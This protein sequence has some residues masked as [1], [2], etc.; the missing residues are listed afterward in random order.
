MINRSTQLHD[1]TVLSR[2]ACASVLV[3]F[4]DRREQ[5]H[6]HIHRKP[7]KWAGSKYLLHQAL[8]FIFF[9]RDDIHEDV[10]FHLRLHFGYTDIYIYVYI[11]PDKATQGL[12]L[13]TRLP[14][15]C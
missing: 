7:K 3:T 12:G 13:L 8:G 1:R 15:T 5:S 10:P 14:R 9:V 4:R 11:Y 2:L 6:V